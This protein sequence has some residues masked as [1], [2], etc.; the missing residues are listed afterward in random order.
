MNGKFR[1]Y[2][3][4]PVQAAAALRDED[5]KLAPRLEEGTIIE[6]ACFV[7]DVDGDCWW[8]DPASQTIKRVED[9]R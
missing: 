7:T 6:K 9:D 8:I 5:R 3:A 2:I 4:D 1:D